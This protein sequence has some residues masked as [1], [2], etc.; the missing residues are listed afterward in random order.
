MVGDELFYHT[1]EGHIEARSLRD[2]SSL[3][4]QPFADAERARLILRGST[5]LAFA[6][7]GAGIRFGFRSPLGSLQYISGGPR[8]AED[9]SLS[10][11]DG[12]TGELMQ[13]INLD[14]TFFVAR[15]EF[16]RRRGGMPRLWLVRD[17]N[18]LG[19]E[20]RI[21]DVG[22]IVGVGNQV[23]VLRSRAPLRK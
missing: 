2:G 4:R 5:L 15:R 16:D 13:R 1:S 14:V 23:K 11:F 12:A 10:C 21:D 6:R 18:A 22:L 17:E 19:P 20:V 9:A 8:D 3:W 7:I